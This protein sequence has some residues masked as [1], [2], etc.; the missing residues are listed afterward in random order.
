MIVSCIEPLPFTTTD[1]AERKFRLT[2]LEEAKISQKLGS[3][4]LAMSL[5]VA[6]PKMLFVCLIDPGDLTE[7]EFASVL[8]PDSDLLLGFWSTLKAHYRGAPEVQA[9]NERYR[10]TKA[11]TQAT[12]GSISLPS[13]GP[14]LV[15][16]ESSGSSDSEKSVQ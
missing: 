11:A 9:A 16:S 2:A 5:S 14:T 7:D 6:M 15:T 12:N 4:F 10:P 8:P 1:G 3:D 13:G